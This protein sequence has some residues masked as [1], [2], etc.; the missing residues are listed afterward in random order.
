MEERRLVVFPYE[1]LTAFVK[2]YLYSPVESL[3]AFNIFAYGNSLS[4]QSHSP[5]YIFDE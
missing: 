4:S 5:I 2:N 3:V 1:N